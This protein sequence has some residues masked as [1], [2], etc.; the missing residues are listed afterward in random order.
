MFPAQGVL[1][2]LLSGLGDEGGDALSWSIEL[3]VFGG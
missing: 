3:A 1:P 2:V